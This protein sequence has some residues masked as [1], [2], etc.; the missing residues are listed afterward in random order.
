[1]PGSRVLSAPK[2]IKKVM[3]D[4]NGYTFFGAE[5]A[6]NEVFM[7]NVLEYNELVMIG[8]EALRITPS[9]LKRYEFVHHFS[10]S[11]H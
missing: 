7:K 11:C 3:C 4:L 8:A 6:E 1:M 2:L 5:L 9:F 10:I